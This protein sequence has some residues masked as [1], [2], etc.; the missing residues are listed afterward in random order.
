MRRYN[1]FIEGTGETCV[2]R[3]IDCLYVVHTEKEA[4]EKIEE[5]I[6]EDAADVEF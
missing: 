3:G 5:L 1:Y 6:L 2:R 4:V